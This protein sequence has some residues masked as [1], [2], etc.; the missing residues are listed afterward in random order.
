MKESKSEGQDFS[1]GLRRLWIV[2]PFHCAVR[3]EILRK[4][5]GEQDMEAFP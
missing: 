2:G 3:V 1:M 5:K 4:Y